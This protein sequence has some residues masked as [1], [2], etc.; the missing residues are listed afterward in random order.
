M[1]AA[2]NGAAR[3]GALAFKRI[4]IPRN[5]F[6]PLRIRINAA[7][8]ISRNLR[9]GYFVQRALRRRDGRKADGE[10]QGADQRFEGIFD[11]TGHMSAYHSKT[12][13][14]LKASLTLCSYM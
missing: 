5:I 8:D 1:G 11:G 12:E 3:K 7:L 2:Q 9:L 13:A 14:T 10:C 4:E 6:E